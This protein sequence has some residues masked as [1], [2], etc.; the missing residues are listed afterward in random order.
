VEVRPQVQR[1]YNERIQ[2]DLAGSVWNTGGCRSWYLDR[3]GVN[4]ALWPTF[5]WRYWLRTRRLDPADFAVEAPA[6]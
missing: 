6:G 3:N 5:T 4:R 1:R 2:A